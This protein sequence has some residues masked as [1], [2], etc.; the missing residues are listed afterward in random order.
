M[1]FEA[2]T[3]EAGP[4]ADVDTV[5]VGQLLVA[6]TPSAS[7]FA[8]RAQM[9]GKTFTFPPSTLQP[10][11]LSRG[12]MQTPFERHSPT[13][14]APVAGCL[15]ATPSERFAS[16]ALSDASS[17]PVQ[18]ALSLTTVEAPKQAFTSKHAPPLPFASP[19]PK[20]SLSMYGR[21]FD[22]SIFASAQTPSM[23]VS[24]FTVHFDARRIRPSMAVVASVRVRSRSLR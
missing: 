20:T 16:S 21:S 7:P 4:H 6:T 19:P 14:S 1:A 8:M 12:T 10:D 9:A 3:A 13:G 23:T 24:S 11:P 18:S 17:W 2:G 15:S 22:E 5:F